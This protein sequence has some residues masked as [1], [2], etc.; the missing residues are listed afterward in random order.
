[1]K[2]LSVIVWSRWDFIGNII[3][4]GQDSQDVAYRP[5]DIH[6]LV[7]LRFLS[8]DNVADPVTKPLAQE[9]FECHCTTMGLM[10]KGD[11]L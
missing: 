3:Y 2:S 7:V 5:H 9:V 1:M 11:W 8:T 10:H 6:Q 4:L